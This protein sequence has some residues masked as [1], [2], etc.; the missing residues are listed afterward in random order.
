M[1]EYTDEILI[2]LGLLFFA[3][4]T[5][6]RREWGIYLIIL[7]LPTY[8]IR[9]QL[10]RIPMTFLEGMILILG[11]IEFVRFIILS[12]RG[13]AAAETKQSKIQKLR[14]DAHND[15]W[16]L[17][18]ILLFLLAA[19]ISVFV[20]PVRIKAAGV[21]KAYFAEA[22]LFCFLTVL[23]IDTQKKLQRLWKI[24]AILVLYLSIFGIYQ[25]ITLYGLP[26]NWW[27]VDV[28]SRRITSLLN[29]PNALALLLGPVIAMLLFLPNKRKLEWT[30]IILGIA[31][32]Y[33]SFSRAAWLALV[34]TVL[35][36]L[37]ITS[38]PWR[39]EGLREGLKLLLAIIVIV[40]LILVV[41]FSR[42]KILDLVRGRDLSQQNRYV[43][44]SAA[45]DMLKKSPVLGV[46]L[47]GFHEAY[48][49]YPLGPDRVVQ[50]YPHNFFLNFWLETGLLGL[51]SI[52]GLL[53]LFYKKVYLL[54][55]SPSPDPSPPG[56]GKAENDS[57]PL[58][59]EDKGGGEK[60]LVLVA[61]AGM[62]MIILHGL[63]DVSYFKNDLSV[64]FWLIY[65]LPFLSLR[66]AES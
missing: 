27:A 37:L 44:W 46:G 56:R 18:F 16:L 3:L 41:P 57:S 47:M 32:L 42:T 59:G 6:F 11:A 49:N 39:G 54:L 64:L 22:V 38:L 12:L 5:V 62:S 26:F 31:A 23:I 60:S 4:V 36:W 13:T 8:Q 20:S 52:T 15:K 45:Q 33:L 58:R 55:K 51:I 14:S 61:V 29:H 43:L 66:S 35:G 21:F 40:S 17:I 25:F 28:A 7:L 48:K 2:I 9:F 30:S 34:L 53:I 1:Y 19:L 24:L 10:A 50:N 63:V 65:A